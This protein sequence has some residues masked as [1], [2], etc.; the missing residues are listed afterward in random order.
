[1]TKRNHPDMIGPRIVIDEAEKQNKKSMDRI[2]VWEDKI[3]TCQELI[4]MSRRDI[5]SNQT[6]IKKALRDIDEMGGVNQKK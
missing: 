4:E 1:M 5:A 2:L 3:R 6:L